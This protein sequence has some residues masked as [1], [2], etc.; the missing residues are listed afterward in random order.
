MEISV[1]EN[2]CIACGACEAMADDYFKV[3]I[4]CKVK[5]KKVK[6]EDEK[7]I[8]DV[9]DSCPVQAIKLSE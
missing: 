5:Q 3:D 6:K 2:K 9:A 4:I 1:D 8:E 7:K